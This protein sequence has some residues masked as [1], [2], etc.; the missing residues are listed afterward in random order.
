MVREAMQFVPQSPSNRFQIIQAGWQELR[1]STSPFLLG[2]GIKINAAPIDVR[3][4][5][6]SPP[7]MVFADSP[8]TLQVGST[9]RSH[10]CSY[11]LISYLNSAPRHVGCNAQTF[12]QPV[13]HPEL[14]CH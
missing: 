6:L 12:H 13:G 11:I 9:E 14:V 8:I 2:A 5:L 7:S 4:K 3:G 1:Y 10:L